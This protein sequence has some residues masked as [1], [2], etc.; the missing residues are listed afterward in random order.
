MWLFTFPGLTV[1]NGPEFA[2]LVAVTPSLELQSTSLSADDEF[3]NPPQGKKRILG[4]DGAH[5]EI[6]RLVYQIDEGNH[7]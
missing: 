4:L 1:Q 6:R 2:A 5:D 7:R 3:V